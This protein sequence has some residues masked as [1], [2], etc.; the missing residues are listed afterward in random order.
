MGERCR[1]C[2]QVYA[3][4]AYFTQHISLHVPDAVSIC[5]I[6]TPQELLA[7][8]R[9]LGWS[10]KTLGG[11]LGMHASRL[12]DFE[13]GH[14]RGK[15]KKRAP[16]PRVVE[17][18]CKWLE[19]DEAQKRPRR[20]MRSGKR[21]CATRR[22]CRSSSTHRSTSRARVSMAHRAT[23]RFERA[24]RHE[25]TGARRRHGRPRPPDGD[26]GA[27]PVAP[28]RDRAVGRGAERHRILERR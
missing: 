14:S 15:V 20:A 17:L 9:R 22:T 27:G 13:T 16:I 28:C 7:F 6:M 8:R 3:P 12:A 5:S 25:S 26:R 23:A 21:C 2:D 10:L 18:A 11:H 24:D 4:T 1:A 19:H